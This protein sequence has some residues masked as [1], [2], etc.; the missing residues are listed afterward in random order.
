MPNVL[1]IVIN[2]DD[3]LSLNDPVTDSISSLATMAATPNSSA[4]VFSEIT[5]VLPDPNELISCISTG[6]KGPCAE[7][8][9]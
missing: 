1:A 3:P 8:S 5:G 4:M 9:R 7:I 6:N 2:N